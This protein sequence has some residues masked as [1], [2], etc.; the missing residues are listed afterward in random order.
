MFFSVSVSSIDSSSSLPKLFRK[1][2]S[3]QIQQLSVNHL[4]EEFKKKEE[5]SH[6]LVK[7]TQEQSGIAVEKRGWWPEFD[8]VPVARVDSS[9]FVN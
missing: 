7:P 1:P 9:A 6:S 3:N 5:G 8:L 2:R 4:S